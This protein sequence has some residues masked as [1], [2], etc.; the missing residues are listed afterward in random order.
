M[1]LFLIVLAYRY[2]SRAAVFQS[3]YIVGD[4]FITLVNCIAMFVCVI[5]IFEDLLYIPIFI[6]ILNMILKHAPILASTCYISVAL[7]FCHSYIHA[8]PCT[9]AAKETA[10]STQ[11]YIEVSPLKYI[12]IH[13]TYN[14]I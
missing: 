13:M 6:Q 10:V 12:H 4:R 1:A 9:T 11:S 5:T 3:Y 2:I 14:A 7:W 8:E